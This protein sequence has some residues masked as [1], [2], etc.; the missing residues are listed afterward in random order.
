MPFGRTFHPDEANQAF[1]TG[2]LLES[3]SYVYDPKDH[4]GPTL[5]YAAAAI[6]K[7]AGNASTAALDANLLRTTPLLFAVA[8]LVF[9]FLAVRRIAKS[10]SS[11][12]AFALLLATAP[13]FV[14]FATDFIQEMLLVCFTMMCAWSAA[15]YLSSGVSAS[16][17]SPRGKW[18]LLFGASAGLA[19][20]T[21]ETCVLS[22]AAAALASVPFV[23]RLIRNFRNQTAP[24]GL[25]FPSHAILAFCAFFLVSAIFY[26]SFGESWR[27]VLDAFVSAPLSYLHRA[28]GDA[29]SEGAAAHVHPWWQ[30]LKWVFVGKESKTGGMLLP[31][32]FS[33][34][35]VAAQ[36]LILQIPLAAFA[37]AKNRLA[38][39][40]LSVKYGFGFSLLYTTL[41]LFLYSA[42]PYK[43][44]WCSL[45]IVAA[46]MFTTGTGYALVAEIL[47]AGK[48]SRK[49]FAILVPVALS[50]AAVLFEHA[51]SLRKFIDN[52]DSKEI[53]CNYASASP[54]AIDMANAIKSAVSA[55]NC[56]APFVAIA[57]PAEDT[58]PL[59]FYLRDLDANVGY[60]TSFEELESIAS[61]GA[62]PDVVVV[63][64]EKGHLVQPL[65]PHLKNTKRFEI[66]HRVRIRVFW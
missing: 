10:A 39:V 52:P 53:P 49:F 1:K 54:Q 26:S 47:A 23:P 7:A 35:I 44:P 29:S 65:F 58:W 57:V 19:F 36:L 60:W 63:P 56:A 42:I 18:A 22:F 2:R 59:P 32:C 40:S 15:G 48:P 50:L 46:L 55:K 21:K 31:F 17:R 9:G 64:A 66:R 5:Y 45:Q 13:F 16:G 37:F 4:H 27:G 12:A 24:E 51:P 6:Q 38:G 34:L 11:A 33:E 8:A 41:L 43:T 14:F 30:H 3:G 28:A 62:K 61:I 25:G 20:A